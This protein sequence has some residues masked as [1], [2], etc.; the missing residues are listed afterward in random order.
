MKS[1][2]FSQHSLAERITS[3]R[4]RT[5]YTRSAPLELW[6]GVECTFNRVGDRYFNQL[7]WNG[8]Q[9]RSSDLDLFADLG[10]CA[11]RYP[12]VWEAL[13]PRQDEEIDWS[14]PDERLNR[15]RD[16]GIAPIADLVHHGSGPR[17]AEITSPD[18]APGLAD[19]ARQVA[20]RYPWIDAYTPV[21]EPLTT[22]R[23]CGLYGH[24][25]PHGTSNDTFVRVLL[26]ECHAIALSMFAVREINPNAK[27]VQTDDL[28][29]IYSTPHMA[30]QA[31][32]ENARRWLAF[33][34]LCGRLDPGHEMWD[35]MVES[36]ATLREL[37]WFCA[38]P[39]PPDIMG[40]N[41]YP[42]SDRYLDENLARY[43]ENTHGTNG[44]ERYA[45]V[46]AV[47]VM[48]QPL[49]G[50][51]ERLCE[52]WER[53]QIP[54]AITEAHLGC[55]REEQVRWT[56][57]AWR[58]ADELREEGVDVRAVTVWSLLGAYNW[59]T[60]VTRDV[61][62]YEPGVF[63]VRGETPRPT[64][65]ASLLRD[66]ST[67]GAGAHPVVHQ[68][69]WWQRPQRILYPGS[70]AINRKNPIFRWQSEAP[71][72]AISPSRDKP[73]RPLLIIGSGSDMGQAFARACEQRGLPFYGLTREN[74][75][76]LDPLAIET[77]LE[78]AN[79]WAVINAASYPRV[80][81]AE[82]DS[83]A[84]FAVNTQAAT[85]LANA[86]ARCGIPLICFSSDLV[87]DGQNLQ[88]Y[89]ENDAPAPLSVYGRSKSEMENQV[90]AAHPGAL[91][92]RSG[93]LF[94]PHDNSN[95]VTKAL[96]A[97]SRG[98]EFAAVS[99]VQISPTY[100]PD[101]VGAA[102]DLLID[103]ANGIW[104]LSNGVSTTWA[105]LARSAAMRYGLDT[106]KIRDVSLE[107]LPLCA[108]LPR[109]SALGSRHG[110]LLPDL[111]SAI[112]R[113]KWDVRL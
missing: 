67:Q 45:D 30:Y 8:H 70:E 37:E 94:G 43:P 101:F 20:Q 50:F 110:Q 12:V 103:G 27:L 42:T 56:A 35:Y 34:L 5:L 95:F 48:S 53:Y 112:D 14:W 39:C 4:S 86:C 106:S 91:I 62:F 18:F 54:L 102:L 108:S 66:L 85:Y 99:D 49:G 98:E 89:R 69:G 88:P 32:F 73:M 107:E 21:N 81:A 10:I 19:F 68:P 3:P 58:D 111:E 36:G 74:I 26:N 105:D 80:D 84:C 113:Y 61:G 79:P 93:A 23:F 41:H 52:A 78:E 90:L 2:H 28:G 16:L 63:D 72:M 104:H 87:F 77:A 11:I 71:K 7:E 100:V 9:H 25:Y 76:I 75:D 17:Y 24:W 33:D 29:H 22:A 51:K 96:R 46:E 55:T 82:S 65:I 15:L 6:G 64:A 38:H 109:F 92:T 40:I 60:L 47:R 57:A 44:R 59:N 13:A 83:E 97:L 1:N 31:N